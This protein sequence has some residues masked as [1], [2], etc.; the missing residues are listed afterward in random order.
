MLR[1]GPHTLS[2]SG[3]E[4]HLALVLG[5]AGAGNVEVSVDDTIGTA[6]EDP[7][8]VEPGIATAG[9]IAAGIGSRHA[10]SA[11]PPEVEGGVLDMSSGEAVVSAGVGGN[12]VVADD[13]PGVEIRNPVLVCTV[14][15][16]G[17]VGAVADGGG[18]AMRGGE[19]VVSADIHI[20][21]AGFLA[22][23]AG[24]GGNHPVGGGFTGVENSHRQSGYPHVH[25]KLGWG[26]IGKN[27]FF[28][29]S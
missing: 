23:D 24:V 13:S 19:A 21:T 14:A 8:A 16:V 3:G 17:A 4:E 25:T 1:R 15:I 9:L 7:V 11:G 20:E 18:L 27:S 22:D 26:G 29:S 28:F 5:T 2:I 6:V 12:H 10:S